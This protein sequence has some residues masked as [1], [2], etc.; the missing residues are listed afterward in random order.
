MTSTESFDIRSYLI[1]DNDPASREPDKTPPKNPNRAAYRPK[2]SASVESLLE[3]DIPSPSLDHDPDVQMLMSPTASLRRSRQEIYS[4]APT[5]RSSS[6]GFYLEADRDSCGSIYDDFND[7]LTSDFDNFHQPFQHLQSQ[8][9]RPTSVLPATQL[10]YHPR[11]YNDQYSAPLYN[12]ASWSSNQS[13]VY[14]SYLSTSSSSTDHSNTTQ[15]VKSSAKRSVTPLAVESLREELDREV[16]AYEA[17]RRSSEARPSTPA[18]S[19][20][21]SL[22]FSSSTD[23][24]LS[25]IRTDT[26]SQ[27]MAHDHKT[28]EHVEQRV[29]KKTA[30]SPKRPAL[31]DT[32]PRINARAR[33]ISAPIPSPKFTDVHSATATS[34]Q[35]TPP[36][37]SFAPTPVPTLS[38]VEVSMFDDSDDEEGTFSH[39]VKKIKSA[40][41]LQN[42]HTKSRAR[43]ESSTH[44]SPRMP[45]ASI[46]AADCTDDRLVQRGSE[47]TVKLRNSKNSDCSTGAMMAKSASP[48]LYHSSSSRTDHGLSHSLMINHSRASSETKP[49]SPV[50]KLQKKM[51]TGSKRS[52]NV[53]SDSSTAQNPLNTPIPPTPVCATTANR[54]KS[55]MSCYSCFSRPDVTEATDHSTIQQQ[56]RLSKASKKSTKVLPPARIRVFFKKIYRLRK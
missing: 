11:L 6:A 31:G 44:M 46:P 9:L 4:Y 47:G 55:R 49:S 48:T 35:Y 1:H 16:S 38:A 32:K 15:R 43:A 52:K 7:D 27:R 28:M 54:K 13:T 2:I 36:S 17:S 50:A 40:V 45:S 3:F 34:R 23:G 53:S 10:E 41:S 39:H 51:S 24:S 12:T 14:S 19:L 25:S 5:F 18:P 30:A 22:S 8:I 56:K 37:R 29:N 33:V 20:L 42:L 21:P 26:S